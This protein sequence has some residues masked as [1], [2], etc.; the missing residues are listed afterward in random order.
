MLCGAMY[1]RLIPQAGEEALGSSCPYQVHCIKH[2]TL[3]ACP[4]SKVRAV[5]RYCML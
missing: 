3:F 1:C 4:L 2:A 5:V